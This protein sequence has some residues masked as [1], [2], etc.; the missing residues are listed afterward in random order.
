[1]TQAKTGDTVK[2]HYTGTLDDGSTFDTSAEREPLEFTLGDK[3]MIP[4][5]ENAVM[6]MAVDES[7]TFKI[8]SDEAYGPHHDERIIEM[9]R[10]QVPEDMKIE[11]GQ[12]LEMASQDGQRVIVIVKEVTEETLKLDANHPL[13]GQD[14]NFEIKLVE[15]A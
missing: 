2:V 15:V 9:G 1:M 14:L 12:Q 3:Q 10:D 7:K 4:G 13:A 6:G 5:F 11:V 8:P